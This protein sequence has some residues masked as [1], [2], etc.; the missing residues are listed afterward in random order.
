MQEH[1][2]GA[3]AWHAEWRPLRELLVAVGSAAAW[4]RACL[5]GLVVHPDVMRANL[6]R[7][8]A[9]TDPLGSAGSFVDAALAAHARRETS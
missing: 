5:T 3:G 8:A 9:A 7:A 4:L 2:R 6:D 1:Q